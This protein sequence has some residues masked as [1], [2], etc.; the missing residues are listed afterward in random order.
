MENINSDVVREYLEKYPDLPSLT[1][2][3]F[4][5]NE[6][7]EVFKSIESVRSSVR[8]YRG[9][10]GI[11]LLNALPNRRFVR[12]KQKPY[13]P[14]ALPDSDER[15]FESFI[16]P[17][18][19]N[20]LLVVGDIHIPYHSVNSLNKMME[21]AQL[22]EID[23]ILFNGDIVDCYQLSRFLKDPRQRDMQAE[24]ECIKSILDIFD[25]TF[26]VKMFFKFG[27]HEERLEH[28]LKFKAPELLGLSEFRLENLLNFDERNITLIKDKR[29]VRFGKLNILHGHELAAG[30]ISPVNAARG[31]FLKTKENTLV[32]HFHTDSKHA[33]PTLNN[34][35]ISCWSVGCMCELH[36]EYAVHNRWRNGF[37]IIERT[38]KD[39][40]I[41]HSRSIINGEIF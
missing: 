22:S 37:A 16:I 30:I 7:K 39:N 29:T 8:Y 13:N 38:D 11:H 26:G 31:V 23:S 5:Y 20:K 4:I 3:R 27:N 34:N 9:A 14:F 35:H 18:T 24:L 12:E 17:K 32:N 36:P 40:F 2:A 25:E 10:S 28:Y 21:Y 6:N 19:F 41:V 33:E 15:E 1:L